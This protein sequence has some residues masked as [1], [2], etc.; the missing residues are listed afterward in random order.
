MLFDTKSGTF[1]EFSGF[2]QHCQRRN[3]AYSPEF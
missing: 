1:K 2:K 3:E